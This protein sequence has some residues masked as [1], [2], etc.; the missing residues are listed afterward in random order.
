MDTT[1]KV[2]GASGKMGY[3]SDETKADITSGETRV[4]EIH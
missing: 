2:P 1:V 3:G 4:F